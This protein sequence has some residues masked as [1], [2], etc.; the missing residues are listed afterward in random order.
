ISQLLDFSRIRSGTVR[1]EPRRVDL[2]EVFRNAIAEVRQAVPDACI[3]MQV[4]G[5]LL[6]ALDYDRMAQVVSNLLSNA[7]QH[8]HRG[9]VVTVAL[10]GRDDEFVRAEIAN[11][12]SITAEA[13]ARLFEPFRAHTAGNDGLGLG[14]YIVARFVEAHQGR[15]FVDTDEEGQVVF[16]FTIPRRQSAEF[17]QRE[18][19]PRLAISPQR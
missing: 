2:G 14:L 6:T 18:D 15:V 8:G 13:R 4:D 11:R 16:G 9:E 19:A 12:G 3:E 5:N 17:R 7:V 1:L 10:D